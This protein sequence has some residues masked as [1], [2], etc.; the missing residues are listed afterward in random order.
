MSA[1]MSGRTC[2]KW[3]ESSPHQHRFSSLGEHNHCRNPDG[4]GGVWCYTTDPDQRWE[5]CSV[6]HCSEEGHLMDTVLYI[7]REWTCKTGLKLATLPL[8]G[9][10][11]RVR[12]P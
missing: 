3:T 11:W 6:P 7:P 4:E 1:T 8:L 5:L 2:Q 9:K 10:Q 12:S